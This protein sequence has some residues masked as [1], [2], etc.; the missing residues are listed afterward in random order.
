MLAT[1]ARLCVLAV[2]IL[3]ATAALGAFSTASFGAIGDTQPP[4]TQINSGPQRGSVVDGSSV[5]F[6]F[7]GTDNRAVAGYQVKN[8]KDGVARR[9]VTASSP[10][11]YTAGLAS[12]SYAFKVRAVDTN[13]NPD[14]TPAVRNY[15]VDVPPPPAP[16][17]VR[18]N[19]D[20]YGATAGDSTDDTQEFKAA[21]NATGAGEVTYVPA[22]VGYRLAGLNPPS[23]TTLQVEAGASL[24]KFGTANGPILR[25]RGS[26]N[27]TWAENIHIVGV[28]GT[29]D[30][31]TQDAGQETAGIAL[32]NVRHYSVKNMVCIQNNSNTTQEAPSSRRPCLSFVASQSAPVN[33]VYQHPTDGVHKNLSSLRS[34]YGWGLIQTTGGQD[35][36]FTNISGEGG[37]VLRLE[38]Y[39]TNWTPMKNITAN[40]VTCQSGHTAVQ[41]NPHGATHA[42]NIRIS[43]VTANSCESGVRMAGDGTYGP[44]VTIDG[45]A[46]NGG[47]TAL[48]RDPADTTYVGAWLI[49]PSRW[50][51][52]DQA[53]YPVAIT[54]ADCGGLPNR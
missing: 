43:G 50:C 31:D 3:L 37:S 29:F 30:L 19:V 20:D 2:T 23:D 25:L 10:K 6:G 18:V 12:G 22:K 35:L 52:D 27:T 24:K 44:G 45:L 46:M 54:N 33:G 47:T 41:M 4:Q 9:W 21:M 38:N 32:A 11:S 40:G 34:P 53:S 13:S 14:P 8:V 42:G 7:S 26:T 36:T 17:V 49:G 39:S 1:L 15:S 16:D 5:S 51:I 48:V 28:N